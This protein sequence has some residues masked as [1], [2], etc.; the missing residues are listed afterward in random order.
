MRFIFLSSLIFLSLSLSGQT[1][2]EIVIV[3][4]ISN[5]PVPYATVEAGSTSFFSDRYGYFTP[6]LIK[7][8][9]ITITRLGYKALSLSTSEISDTIKLIPAPYNLGTVEISA[10]E[11]KKEAGYHDLKTYGRTSGRITQGVGVEIKNLPDDV[12][13]TRVFAHTKGNKKGAT[14]LISLFTL[15]SIGL[16][17]DLLYVRKYVSPN[18]R[19]KISVPIDKEVKVDEKLI[20]IFDWIAIDGDEKQSTDYSGVRMTDE[21]NASLSFLYAKAYN[22]W[23]RFEIEESM[24]FHWNYKIGVEYLDN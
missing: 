4:Q 24:G 7:N 11:K 22:R 18:G 3:D 8:D 13:I 2:R 20:V 1:D 12:Q 10:T 6:G 14:Y 23:V 15:D 16:P 19:N 17:G 5:E 9:E 21:I